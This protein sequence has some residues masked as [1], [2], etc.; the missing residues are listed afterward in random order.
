MRHALDL[1]DDRPDE[2][3]F[4]VHRD[5]FRD[6]AI[7][8]LEMARFF[9][10]GWV[11]VGHASQVPLPHDFITVRIGRSP[12]IISRDGQGQLLALHNSCRHKGSVVCHHSSGNRRAH[13]CPYHGWSYGSDGRNILIK[14]KAEGGYASAFDQDNH[15]LQ[16]VAQF[17]QYRGFMF[18]SLSSDV[19]P[20]HEHLGDVR[21]LIDLA[22]DQSPEGLE[23]VPGVVHYRFEANWKMQ[24]ENTI[25]AYHFASTH[26]SYLRLQE[27]RAS[28]PQRA[29]APQTI[30]QSANKPQE[31]MG[32]F[33][34]PQGHAMVW[35]T[36]PVEN[37]PLYPQR[38]A[39]QSRVGP[40]RTQWMMRT[41]QLNVFPNLQIASSAA[42]QMRVIQ[43]VSVD[44]TEITSY[45]LAP[46]GESAPQRRQRLRQYEDFFNPSGLA[47]PDDTVIFEDCQRG[48]ASGAIEWQQG[49]ARGMQRRIFGP[50]EHA[51]ELGIQP[52]TS[53]SGT[54][55]MSDE[56]VF[57]ALYRHWRGGMA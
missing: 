46:V 50:D 5:V 32:A 27:R 23:L 37:H 11:F 51:Q 38:D 4:R 22:V 34:F 17:A 33:G 13:L 28:M 41:R 45:C 20:L 48:M 7:F 35:T 44:R 26:P 52:L 6:P 8:E 57:H 14:D 54:F 56:T 3:V 24:L 19:P 36:T 53:V 15:D 40:V 25:D 18:A 16:A 2:G 29:D 31:M 43:P 47:T 1:I 42:I 12:V 30:W 21:T 49:H 10:R 9:E 39:L 55:E